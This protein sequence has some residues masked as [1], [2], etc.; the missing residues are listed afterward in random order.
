MSFV[1]NEMLESRICF[2][3]EEKESKMAQLFLS[4]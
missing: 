3:D 1:L 4:G 2:I